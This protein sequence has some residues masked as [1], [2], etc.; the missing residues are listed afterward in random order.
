[1][2]SEDK[3]NLKRETYLVHTIQHMANSQLEKKES[4]NKSKQKKYSFWKLEVDHVFR[5]LYT[6]AA[7]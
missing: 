2:W 3:T 5:D 4:I 7:P 6:V 1:M